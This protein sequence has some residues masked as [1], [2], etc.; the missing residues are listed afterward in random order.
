MPKL[1]PVIVSGVF[2]FAESGVML[3]IVASIKQ[4]INN[5]ST[6]NTQNLKENKRKAKR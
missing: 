3:V 4:Q 5:D 2:V 1:V 6:A